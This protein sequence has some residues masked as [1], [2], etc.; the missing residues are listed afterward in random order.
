MSMI[1][2]RK[3]IILAALV[4]ALGAAIFLNWFYSNPSVATTARLASSNSLGDANYVA[5]QN[6]SASADIFS[7]AKLT[8]QQTRASATEQLKSIATDAKAT[9]AQKKEALKAIEDIA[10]NTTN[11][12]NIETLVKAKGF[13]DCVAVINNGEI[14]L[15]VRAK[16]T[17]FSK[18]DIA[19][20]QEI[21]MSQTKFTADK[22]H[23]T[24]AK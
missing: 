7:T 16:S 13:K 24:Q 4:V 1:I 15:V 3:Q 2:G 23:I 21:A 8:R 19:Q 6:V 10:A 11:E 17:E 20:I 22:I 14:T 9:D 18:S 12:G 5:N